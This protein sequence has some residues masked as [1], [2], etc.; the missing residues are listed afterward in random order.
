M[1][2]RKSQEKDYA[3]KKDGDGHIYIVTR[4]VLKYAKH[5]A[6][7]PLVETRTRAQR[8]VAIIFPSLGLPSPVT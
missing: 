5:R 6:D 2:S 3:E 7:V 1:V 4:R 8:L